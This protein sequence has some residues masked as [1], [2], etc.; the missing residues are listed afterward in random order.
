MKTVKGR[1]VFTLIELL[2]VVAIIMILASLLLPALGRA[3]QSAHRA[4][5]ASNLKQINMA[6]MAYAY[7]NNE[8][9]VYDGSYLLWERVLIRSGYLPNNYYPNVLNSSGLY[10]TPAM[11]CPALPAPITFKVPG[12]AKYSDYGLNY[13]SCQAWDY[14]LSMFTS[15]K[16]RKIGPKVV[17]FG[18]RYNWPKS[19]QPANG[20][21]SLIY[22]YYAGY[23]I[24]MH[25]GGGANLTFLDGHLEWV[26]KG[27]ELAHPEWWTEYH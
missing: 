22:V 8:W 11:L 21:P 23:P 4:V 12:V 17:T 14:G 16:L 5:C 18:D 9:T 6:Y 15:G 3:R 27:N 2:F 20:S 1:I 10:L 13:T 19:E 25:H 7:D 26:K 24:G